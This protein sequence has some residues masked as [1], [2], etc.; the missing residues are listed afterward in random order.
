MKNHKDTY[1][2][3]RE[4][5]PSI[6]GENAGTGK[7][8][9]IRITYAS[10]VVAALRLLSDAVLSGEPADNAALRLTDAAFVDIGDSLARL[11]ELGR[12]Q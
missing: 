9:A 12:P 11:R 2:E 10:G 6:A 1:Q 5:L 8:L 3:F 4:R 7:E